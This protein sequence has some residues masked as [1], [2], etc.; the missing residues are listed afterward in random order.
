[1]DGCQNLQVVTV[2]RGVIENSVF[3]L[4]ERVVVGKRI[5]SILC[6]VFF[7][8]VSISSFSTMS[9]CQNLQVVTVHRGV[10][11]NLLQL[12]TS[13]YKFTW[14]RQVGMRRSEPYFV[15]LIA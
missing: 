12:S 8:L 2:M 7:V 9:S 6:I 11:Y 3:A 13:C 15:L 10:V 1:M 4:R 14:N 5:I